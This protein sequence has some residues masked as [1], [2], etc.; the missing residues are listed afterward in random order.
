MV[1]VADVLVIL[2]QVFV[3]VCRS[4]VH[5]DISPAARFCNLGAGGQRDGN[6]D[7]IID[8]QE[9]CSGLR[10]EGASGCNSPR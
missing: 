7:F 1:R 9:I 10:P 6:T 3:C 4:G 2:S 8:V 5:A